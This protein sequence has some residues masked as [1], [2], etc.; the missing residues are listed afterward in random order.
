MVASYQQALP[1]SLSPKRVVTDAHVLGGQ[2]VVSGTRIPAATILA[3]L[4]DGHSAADIQQDYPVLTA[5]GIR[6][7]EAWAAEKFG[8]SWKAAT[9]S[10]S[11]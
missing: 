3:Y 2:A 5:D 1:K 7:V 4:R 9:S 10:L 11:D 8:P 6:A